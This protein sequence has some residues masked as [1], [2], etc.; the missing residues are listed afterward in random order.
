MKIEANGITQTACENSTRPVGRIDLYDGSGFRVAFLTI[1]AKGSDAEVQHAIGS[2][3]HGSV[4]VLTGIREVVD[5]YFAVAQC[6]IGLHGVA[7][8]LFVVAQVK[9]IILHCDAVYAF[10][11]AR[12]GYQVFKDI[13]AV[14]IFQHQ[15]ITGIAPGYIKRTVWARIEHSWLSKTG[16]CDGYFPALRNLQEFDH[17]RKEIKMLCILGNHNCFCAFFGRQSTLA[18]TGIKG[19]GKQHENCS[20]FNAHYKW[21]R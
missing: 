11:I 10:E 20:G 8:E 15:H 21:I 2:E 14:L 7:P 17:L 1:V 12:N 5:K 13:V 9:V 19:E 3:F 6:S 16:G 18:V 4:G